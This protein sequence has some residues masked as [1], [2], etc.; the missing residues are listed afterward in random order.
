MCPIYVNRR[1]EVVLCA[2][3]GPDEARYSTRGQSR[4]AK[5]P[6]SVARRSWVFLRRCSLSAQ[7]FTLD[8]GNTFSSL[9]LHGFTRRCGC[10]DSKN[11]SGFGWAGVATKKAISWDRVQ[12]WCS[13]KEACST[14][15]WT[16]WK[17]REAKEILER[18]TWFSLFHP[19]LSPPSD[20][21]ALQPKFLYDS[22]K[23][24]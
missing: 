20:E 2:L 17:R 24:F 22:R 15:K 7:W 19:Q 23:C 8:G 21:L 11:I 9:L 13:S 14:L 16:S 6:P 18:T 12:A 4:W 5:S 3:Q 10:D 1:K